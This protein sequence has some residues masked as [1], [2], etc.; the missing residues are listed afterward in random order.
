M[1]YFQNKKMDTIRY[2]LNI[3]F[4]TLIVVFKY[5]FYFRTV[6]VLKNYED[7]TEFMYSPY[8]VSPISILH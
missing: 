3:F 2:D 1:N 8:P 7:S 5:R 6:L 4:C